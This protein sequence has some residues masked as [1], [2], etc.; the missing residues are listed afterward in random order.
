MELCPRL[1]KSRCTVYLTTAIF[2]HFHS[3]SVLIDARCDG[4]GG[5]GG[6]LR[7][8]AEIYTDGLVWHFIV[9]L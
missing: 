5:G 8:K 7:L 9:G 4:G 3:Q 1:F 6:G 2:V